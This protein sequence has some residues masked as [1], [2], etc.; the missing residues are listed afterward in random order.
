MGWDEVDRRGGGGGT[1]GGWRR[2]ALCLR[3]YS[4]AGSEGEGSLVARVLRVKGREV[5]RLGS[6]PQGCSKSVR[7]GIQVT[8]GKGRGRSRLAR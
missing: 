3:I 1:G 7:D 4:A 2:R 5:N 8:K 6:A